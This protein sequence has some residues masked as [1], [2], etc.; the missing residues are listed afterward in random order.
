MSKELF[1]TDHLNENLGRLSVRGG[2]FT[3]A[4]QLLKFGLQTLSVIILARLLAPEDFGLVAMVTAVT[5][6]AG[7]FKD[8]GL[9]MATIQQKEINEAQIST[10]FWVNFLISCSFMIL[11]M[12]VSP[13]IA[14][15]YKEP[16]LVKITI[17]SSLPFFFAG[18][19]IQH[20]ALLRR[21]MKFGQ[22]AFI[23]V[24]SIFGATVLAIL[25]AVLGGGY[26]AIV[27]LPPIN[28]ILL[29]A[30]VWLI[31][32]WIPGMPLRNT[33]VRSM[34][35]FGGN[36]VGFNA[37][38]YFARNLDKMLIG[39]FYDASSLGYYSQAYRL[40]ML[41]L[42]Q[43]SG[44]VAGVAIPALSRLQDDPERY[45]KYYM[46]IVSLM[47]SVT[48]PCVVFMMVMSKELIVTILGPQWDR[49]SMIFAILAVSAIFQPIT[50]TS[51]WLFISQG[52]SRTM[53]HW[54]FIGSTIIIAS[55]FV[56]LPWGPEG[57]ATAYS[58]VNVLVITPL[59]FW[60]MGRKGPVGVKDIYATLA[61][62]LFSGICIAT[63]LMGFKTL[64]SFQSPL[65]H[66]VFSFG[67]TVVVG[68]GA[69]LLIPSGRQTLIEIKNM[70]KLFVIRKKN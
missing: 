11:L 49:T 23:E 37:I 62:P 53:L 46:K 58:S 70:V 69:F 32:K 31:T 20:Q 38:N 43:I 65:V 24:F 64:A 39:R 68:I 34:L 17:V 63:A 55:F 2:F 27:S 51:G 25:L 33:G 14:I 6:F 15:F 40:L 56:G 21:Q 41:P 66:L 36:I 67:L 48:V 29:A 18:L 45:R 54:G 42:M 61:V 4:G 5:G 7:L 35:S 57:V 19:T 59:L 44:P 60:Y 10:L 8:M 28:S 52:R 9:S 12:L 50:Y 47:T 26:W 3:I 22:L 16:L 1:K 30:G 13:L